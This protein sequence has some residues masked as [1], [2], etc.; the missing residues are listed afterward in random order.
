MYHAAGNVDGKERSNADSQTAVYDST[1]MI[2]RWKLIILHNTVM[3][4][5]V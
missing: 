2:R 4:N 5:T 3:T 1:I